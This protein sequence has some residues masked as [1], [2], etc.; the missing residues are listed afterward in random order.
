MPYQALIITRWIEKKNK[1]DEELVRRGI[2]PKRA[3]N[4]KKNLL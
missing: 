1:G 2:E 4:R 3:Y